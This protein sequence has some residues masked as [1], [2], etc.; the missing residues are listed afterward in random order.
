[1]RKK[2]PGFALSALI[3][4]LVFSACGQPDPNRDAPPPD[5]S[6]SITQLRDYIRLDTGGFDEN[7]WVV[8]NGSWDS[9]ASTQGPLSFDDPLGKLYEALTPLAS[10][11]KKIK[12]DFTRVT[13]PAINNGGNTNPGERGNGPPRISAVRFPAQLTRIGEYS[14]KGCVNLQTVIFTSANPPV[15]PQNA[16]EGL[17]TPLDMGV[18]TGKEANYTALKTIFENANTGITVT[19]FEE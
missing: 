7:T 2:T 17:G 16:V 1:M 12:L 18:P 14:F 10:A 4:S 8:L 6:L 15:I 19:V 13:G 5:G 9:F 3:F 11:G